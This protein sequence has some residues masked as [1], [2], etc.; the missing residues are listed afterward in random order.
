MMAQNTQRPAK[1]LSSAWMVAMGAAMGL[2][3]IRP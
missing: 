2:K 3:A 1:G